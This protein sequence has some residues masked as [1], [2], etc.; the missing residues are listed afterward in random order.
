VAE[1]FSSS[2]KKERIKKR[3]YRTRDLAKAEIEYIEVFY[4]RTRPTG[5]SAA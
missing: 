4:N 2:L 1:Y 3:I 5:I